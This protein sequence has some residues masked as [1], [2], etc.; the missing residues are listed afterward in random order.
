MAIKP[1]IG[2]R[3]YSLS[4]LT[5]SLGFLTHVIQ[6]QIGERS[7]TLGGLDV[8]PAKLSMLKIVSANP[9]IR[10]VDVARL[11]AVQAP[12]MVGLVKGLIDR[13]WLVRR[14]EDG[15]LGLWV[16]DSGEAEIA[17]WEHLDAIERSHAATLSDAEYGQLLRLLNRIYRSALYRG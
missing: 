17:R 14:R 13:E 15:S 5:D 10:Q 6:V 8:S 7:R 12:N 16:T 1:V 2:I 9:G 4:E 3:E 11:M